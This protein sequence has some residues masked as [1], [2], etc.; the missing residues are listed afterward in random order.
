MSPQAA[1]P[2]LRVGLVAVAVNEKW[3]WVAKPRPIKF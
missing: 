1:R 3:A 2:I